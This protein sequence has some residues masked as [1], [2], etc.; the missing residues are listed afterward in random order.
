METK[1][2]KE[3][4]FLYDLYIATDWAERFAALVDEHIELPKQGRALYV[5]AGTAGHAL[6]LDGREDEL[7]LIC[8]DENPEC[9]EIAQAKAVAL[10][11]EVEFLPEDPTALSFK[12]DQFDLV[13]GDASLIAPIRLRSMLAEMV[14][15]AKPGAALA[16]WFPTA[17]SFGE[18]FSIYWEALTRAGMGDHSAAVEN[19]IN[20]L[21]T[22]ANVESWA[23]QI[24]LES[25][26]V[27]TAVEEFHYDSGE[28]FLA[29]PMIS[30]FLLPN[31]FQ[32]VP[33]ENQDR[34]IQELIGIIDEERH[35]GEFLLTLKATLV[36]GK[37]SFVQ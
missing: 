6:A 10:H 29:S 1:S 15:V 5:A 33:Q 22:V 28:Q 37:K 12:D 14:R 34:V 9:L 26:T 32:R 13:L 36:V 27:T 31:W 2:P 3:L 19:L 18:V 23:D 16:A 4:A 30:D 8:V 20:E 35:D 7:S 21:P 25:V 24:G 17:A 11:Q